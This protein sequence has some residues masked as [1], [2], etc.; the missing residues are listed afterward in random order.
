MSITAFI[1]Y[2]AME[3]NYSTHTMEAYKH[4]LNSF[5]SFLKESHQNTD[6]QIE[7]AQQQD[8]KKWIIDLSKQ[9]LTFKTINRKLAALKTYYSFLKKSNQIEVSPFEK[10]IPTLKVEKTMKL[11]FSGDEIEKTLQLFENKDSFEEIRNFTIIEMLYSTG[12]RRSELINL[13]LNDL[14]F[15]LHQLKVLGKRN[16]ERIIPMLPELE[17]SLKEYL[18]V[19]EEVANSKS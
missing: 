8:V 19:R 7:V 14:D 9:N 2:L 1:N 16:K 3:R 5:E 6:F 18:S 17:K 10:G 4:D 12:I 11:P 13:K 15:S